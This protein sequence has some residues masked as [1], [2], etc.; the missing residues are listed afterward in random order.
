MVDL[1]IG[2]YSVYK[3]IMHIDLAAA[4][5]VL[6]IS[7]WIGEGSQILWGPLSDRGHH[8]RL[9]ALG[10]FLT[11]SSGLLGY[12]S[13]IWAI[14][15]LILFTYIGSA[16]FHPCAAGLAGTLNPDK[17]GLYLA[18]YASGGAL[19]LAASQILFYYCYQTFNGHVSILM[20]PSI[21]VIALLF[22]CKKGLKVP[23]QPRKSP[24]VIRQMLALF[25]D[26]QMRILYGTQVANQTLLWGTIFLLPD[27]LLSRGCEEWVTYGGGHL[28]F[29]LGMGCM[30]IPAGLVADRFSPRIV[31]LIGTSVGLVIFY[32]FLCFP[33]Q[34]T[35]VVMTE[36]FMLGA[37]WGV[38]SPVGLAL[39]SRLYPD[40]P[41]LVSAFLMGMVWCISESLGPSSGSL[42]KLF[43]GSDA[44][45]QA[46][47]V[48][49]SLGFFASYFAWLLPVPQSEELVAA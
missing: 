36:L 37:C 6:S 9:I 34:T 3:T 33:T 35:S 17:R 15:P 46:L 48:L 47:L 31:M 8:K 16:A 21:L 7:A 29:V 18:I 44:P 19:G 23:H 43:D 28:A 1:M 5:V 49:G 42:T 22:L 27:V 14:F 25:K 40:R 13:T 20:L 4:G 38:I 12:V 24:L 30:M 32:S 39:G 45:A 10:V 11:A 2:I 26:R 41:G